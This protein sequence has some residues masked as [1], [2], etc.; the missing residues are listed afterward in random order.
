MTP[1]QTPPGNYSL[2]WKVFGNGGELSA[3]RENYVVLLIGQK[4]KKLYIVF[5]VHDRW[6]PTLGK[7]DKFIVDKL[8]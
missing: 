7:F 2:R 3:K 1:Y 5:L 6:R 4:F 8:L